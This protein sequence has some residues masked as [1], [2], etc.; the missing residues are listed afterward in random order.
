MSPQARYRSQY[1]TPI[2]IALVFA[3][4]M[5]FVGLGAYGVIS[6]YSNEQFRENSAK[7]GYMMHG[8]SAATLVLLLCLSGI[9]WTFWNEP[10]LRTLHR[11]F[12]IHFFASAVC[13]VVYYNKISPG[14]YEKDS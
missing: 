4:T 1:G 6:I 5:S 12:L 2:V 8:V 14:I 13:T 10:E 3:V 7:V 9:T 11:V